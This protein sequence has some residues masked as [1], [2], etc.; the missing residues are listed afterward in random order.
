MSRFTA[1]VRLVALAAMLQGCVAMPTN[2]APS[3]IERLARADTALERGDLER[4]RRGYESVIEQSP[5]L[6]SPYFQLGLIA[7]GAADPN[8]AIEH[9][10][11]AL[12]RD[13]GHVLATYNLAIV[14][15]QQARLL[16]DQHERLAPVSAGQPGLVDLRR[17][18]DALG[19]APP[20]RK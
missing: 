12:A 13:P 3:V 15:L 7:Y 16:L 19:K 8:A 10:E 4:A 2:H 20:T 14:H 18:I 17:A 11:A 1:S 5:E 6:V 9:F